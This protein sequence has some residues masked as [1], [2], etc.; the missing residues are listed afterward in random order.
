MST[1]EEPETLSRNGRFGRIL[2]AFSQQRTTKKT[3]E[4]QPSKPKFFL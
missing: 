4:V 2:T 3:T 1:K